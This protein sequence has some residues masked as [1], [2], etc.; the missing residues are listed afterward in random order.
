MLYRAIDL[1]GRATYMDAPNESIPFM[2]AVN[3]GEIELK[4]ALH[5]LIA[6]MRVR[7]GRGDGIKN[8]ASSTESDSGNSTDPYNQ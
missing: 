6:Y 7:S 2:D 1:C 5:M 8:V 4:D 3:N